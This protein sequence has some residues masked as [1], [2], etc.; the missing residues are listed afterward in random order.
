MP[1]DNL[2]QQLTLAF[3]IDAPGFATLAEMDPA[4]ARTFTAMAQSI[5]DSS[6]L[7]AREQALIFL[8]LNATLVHLN[9]PMVRAY[10]SA[11]LDAGATQG[12]I[13]E[14]LQLTSVIGVHGT[15][16]GVLILTE[17]E[18]GLES[19][20]KLESS[21]RKIRAQQACAAF[22]AKRGAMTPAWVACAWQVPE[23]VETYADFSGVPW[24]THHLSARMKE[25]VYVAIDLMPQ[26]T[27]LEGT[28]VHMK[29]ARSNGASEDDIR[30]VIKMITLMGIQT[31]LLALPILAE[32]LSRRA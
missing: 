11:A 27:H 12:E 19:L 28:R 15:M 16:P 20:E 10:I 32:E 25:L 1:I 24:S 14:V 30:S 2:A 22:I 6:S 9:K 7:D 13:Q 5:K 3:G 4:S 18:G 26:H 21:P 31:H 17:E 8:A 23:L 29:K